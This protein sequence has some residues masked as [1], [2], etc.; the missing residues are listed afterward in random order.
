MSQCPGQDHPGQEYKQK[1]AIKETHCRNPSQRR[2]A[3]TWLNQSPGTLFLQMPSNPSPKATA[4]PSSRTTSVNLCPR[5]SSP[6]ASTS[7]PRRP[8]LRLPP[9][10]PNSSPHSCARYLPA[11][12]HL[13][14]ISR[15]SRAPVD[16]SGWRLGRDGVTDDDS[17]KTEKHADGNGIA[18]ADGVGPCRWRRCTGLVCGLVPSHSAHPLS[19]SLSLL[20]SFPPSP[21]PSPPPYSS[22]PSRSP[23]PLLC[24]TGRAGFELERYPCVLA[25]SQQWRSTG[26][27][28]GVARA[29]PPLPIVLPPRTHLSSLDAYAYARVV[30][31]ERRVYHILI[32]LAL[33]LVIEL[34]KRG[35]RRTLRG[36]GYHFG[37]DPHS[38]VAGGGAGDGEFERY[39]TASS[40]AYLGL[41]L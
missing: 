35:V 23:S 21:T 3:P 29:H 8:P 34:S 14:R 36:S 9:P 2:S 41:Y 22:P 24:G 30:E 20:P 15:A 28:T 27:G 32:V 39:A 16:G 1:K 40:L 31:A 25:H 5:T 10:A 12:A 33:A 4:T 37:L 17:M 38:R 26:A 11:R 13:A 6:V 18:D 7:P 19:P